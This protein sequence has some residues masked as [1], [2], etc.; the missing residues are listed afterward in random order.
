MPALLCLSHAASIRA[1][2]GRLFPIAPQPLPALPAN[3]RV[4]GRT[5]H[6]HN[7]QSSSHKYGLFQH[8]CCLWAGLGWWQLCA[9][10]GEFMGGGCPHQ[11]ALGIKDPWEVAPLGVLRLKSTPVQSRSVF[12]IITDF[13]SWGVL[14]YCYKCL[15]YIKAFRC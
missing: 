3:T 10:H 12:V 4:S 7:C 13:Y 8:I 6:G 15:M 5:D 11:P 9:M 1:V 14:R 2:S